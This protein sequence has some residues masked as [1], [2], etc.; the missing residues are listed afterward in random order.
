MSH[1]QDV[2][3]GPMDHID[4]GPSPLEGLGFPRASW[5]DPRDAAIEELRAEV[6][7]LRE[8]VQDLRELA[9]SRDGYVARASGL[10]VPAGRGLTR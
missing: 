9:A 8:V 5:V 3:M 6:A 2:K 7:N 1:I 10:L 4:W